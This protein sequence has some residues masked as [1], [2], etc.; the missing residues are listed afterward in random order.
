MKK[1]DIVMSYWNKSEKRMSAYPYSWIDN[2]AN[3]YQLFGP[4]PT[5][6]SPRLED[7]MFTFL[8][9]FSAGLWALVVAAL[10]ATGVCLWAIERNSPRATD[11]EHSKNWLEATM[12]SMYL[13]SSLFVGIGGPSPTT[14]GGRLQLLALGF[15]CVIM[16]AAYTVSG[17]YPM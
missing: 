8:K 14:I 5:K 1:Y 17:V 6:K 3:S 10:I 15:S 2:M 4:K 16:L 7:V 13:T 11:Y 12:T 9:P